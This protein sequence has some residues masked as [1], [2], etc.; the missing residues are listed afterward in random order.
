M[1]LNSLKRLR[2]E[3]SILLAALAISV[4]AACGGGGDEPGGSNPTPLGGGATPG[5]AGGAGATPGTA[6]GAG[7]TPGTAGGAGATPGTAGG[8]GA[9]PGTAGG[10]GATPGTA[11]GAG[12]TPGTAG[13]AGGTG[14]AGGTTGGTAGGGTT[15]GAAGGT[16]GGGGVT[17]NVPSGKYMGCQSYSPVSGT[18]DA[19]KCASWYC[20]V[21]L[22]EMK[23]HYVQGMGICATRPAEE[24][25]DN[26]IPIDVGKCAR[27]IKSANLGASNESLRPK[28]IEC[29]RKAN[30]TDYT[31]EKLPDNCLNCF[32]D[33]ANCAGD[34]C[35]IE[36]LL[37]DNKDCDACR[38][39][40][41]CDQKVFTC[42][43]LPN[44]F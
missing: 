22:A 2:P 31:L 17:M 36:C 18:G 39:K 37:D 6:G 43:G 32:V 28:V 21:T 33:V 20:G 29:V 19:K 1:F 8:A 4:G 9:T 5:T 25:C 30:M 16:T 10:A 23:T 24:I 27:E 42:G 12:A 35:L 15:G 34:K 11:G 38:L 3:A 41:N 26:K 40:N 13:G 14:S 44:V 7:A